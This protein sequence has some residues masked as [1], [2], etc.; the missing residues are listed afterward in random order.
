[1]NVKIIEEIHPVDYNV[2]R[3][4]CESSTKPEYEHNKPFK[5]EVLA[6][7]LNL[8]E[9]TVFFLKPGKWL[10]AIYT[11]PEDTT[12][13]FNLYTLKPVLDLVL[14]DD[15]LEKLPELMYCDKVPF[16]TI[17]SKAALIAKINWYITKAG[18]ISNQ[19]SENE[20]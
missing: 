18:E 5:C 17:V 12:Q 20:L 13:S 6:K 15:Q 11:S 16:N 19:V 10:L 3:S 2:F 8:P 9:D 14:N 7:K 1:M 4:I